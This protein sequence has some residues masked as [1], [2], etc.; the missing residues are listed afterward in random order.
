MERV[1]MMNNELQKIVHD[2]NFEKPLDLPRI[3]VVGAQ[4]SGKSSVLESIVGEDFLPRGTDIVTRCPLILQ[5]L[6]SEDG[7]KEAS[8]SHLEDK[9]FIDF[10]KVRDEIQNRTNVLAGCDK[11]IVDEPIYLTIYSPKV[12]NLT[13]IDLPG[14]TK[15]ATD[16]QDKDIVK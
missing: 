3:A 6:H 13:L 16:D 5:L 10:F 15:V 12:P 4:S 11:K 14:I 1:I 7:T 8:F 9:V 2:A